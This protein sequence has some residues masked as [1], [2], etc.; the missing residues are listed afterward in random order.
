M[1]L[2]AIYSAL[3]FF[4]HLVEGREVTI[5]TDHKPLQYAFQQPSI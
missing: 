4:R 3:K 1:M 5:M 2:L